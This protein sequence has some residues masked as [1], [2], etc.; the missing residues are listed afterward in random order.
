MAHRWR[1][2][3]GEALPILRCSTPYFG[4]RPCAVVA[5]TAA[6]G[7][8][9]SAATDFAA[10]QCG[11]LHPVRL[12]NRHITTVDSEGVALAAIQGLHQTMRQQMREKDKETTQLRRKLQAIEAKLGM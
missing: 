9:C 10:T 2:A 3:H 5:A 6:S 1:T 8:P 12:D 7:H 4:K 11:M